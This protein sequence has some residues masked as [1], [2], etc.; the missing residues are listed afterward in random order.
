LNR[1]ISSK[2]APDPQRDAELIAQ[3]RAGGRAAFDELFHRYQ[4]RVFNMAYRILGHREDA[5]D[6]AQEIFL[7]VYRSLPGFAE[8]ARFST[9]LYRVTVNRCRDLLRRRATVKHTRPLSLDA[10]RAVSADDRPADPPAPGASPLEEAVGRETRAVV[11]EAIAALPADL[12][13][14]LVLRDVEQLSYEEV[15]EVLDIPVGT[16]RSRLNRARTTLKE[17]IRP[18]LGVEP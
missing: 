15:A 6:A 8:K 1:P 17:R 5:L 16:V 10:R 3:A 14:I 9:W 2:S 7:I 12:S 13:E 11:E 18:I 4:D